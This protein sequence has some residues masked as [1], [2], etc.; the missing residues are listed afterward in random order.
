[1]PQADEEPPFEEVPQMEEG[2]KGP[3]GRGVEG[4]RKRKRAVEGSRALRRADVQSGAAGL[5][6]LD[7]HRKDRASGGG[8]RRGE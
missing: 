1:M 3:V 7:G 5:S 6:L 4:D 2:A 8:G